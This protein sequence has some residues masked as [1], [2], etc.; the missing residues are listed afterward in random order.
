MKKKDVE[1][2]QLMACIRCGWRTLKDSKQK[3]LMNFIVQ[4]D[5]VPS[6]I[7]EFRFNWYKSGGCDSSYVKFIKR[8]RK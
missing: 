6:D 4:L 2:P 3:I 8:R 7:D 1:V 5:Q